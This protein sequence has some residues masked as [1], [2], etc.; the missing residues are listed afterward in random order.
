MFPHSSVPLLLACLLCGGVV[1]FAVVIVVII[2]II[3]DAVII[4]PRGVIIYVFLCLLGISLSN[5]GNVMRDWTHVHAVV[6][7]HDILLGSLIEF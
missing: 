2:V 4:C 3:V 6:V 5:V 7:L 1:V